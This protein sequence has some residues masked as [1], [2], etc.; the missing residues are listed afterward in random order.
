MGSVTSKDL[1]DLEHII[2]FANQEPVRGAWNFQDIWSGAGNINF[3]RLDE[4]EASVLPDDPVNIQYTSG[5]TGLPKA[6]TLSHMNLRNNAGFLAQRLG[7]DK[8]HHVICIPNPLYRKPLRRERRIEIC[9]LFRLCDIPLA[10]LF[11]KLHL[12][13]KI[14]VQV[15]E[16][17][18]AS[19]FSNVPH[20]FN[21]FRLHN[22]PQFVR[23]ISLLRVPLNGC[24]VNGGT[25]SD[26]ALEEEK[27][28]YFFQL[29]L[30]EFVEEK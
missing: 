22:D 26:K 27:V 15:Q 9:R 21:P 28:L 24:N 1:P 6:A 8:K 17:Y 4:A 11:V 2:V 12:F 5:T 14:M 10:V 29:K 3:K 7:Y 20:D 25:A 23:L 30:V 19:V 13:I 18:L 16:R